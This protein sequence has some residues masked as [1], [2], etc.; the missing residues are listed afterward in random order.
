MDDFGISAL[1]SANQCDIRSF[2]LSTERFLH[3]V[4]DT[5]WCA[6]FV[7][8][9]FEFDFILENIE[10][11]SLL[12]STEHCNFCFFSTYF[13]DN[14]TFYINLLNVTSSNMSH[15]VYF[16]HFGETDGVTLS[17]LGWGVRGYGAPLGT[18]RRLRNIPDR[19]YH[20]KINSKWDLL[21]MRC[22]D[23][24]AGPPPAHVNCGNGTKEMRLNM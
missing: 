1:L 5:L 18:Q 7:I 22:S 24:H 4:N 14:I 19:F 15:L 12:F 16:T 3:Y 13:L 20:I 6:I 10:F 17:R 23:L 8:Q 2:F 11:S 9:A 21:L